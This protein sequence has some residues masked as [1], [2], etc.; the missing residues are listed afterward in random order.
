VTYGESVMSKTR[1]YEW[2]KGFQ[3]GHKNVEDDERLKRL[4]TSTTDEN[5]EKVKDIVINGRRIT[6][7]EMTDDVKVLIG[8]CHDIFLEVLGTNHEWQQNLFQNC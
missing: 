7:K 8:S 1:A 6:M 5:V 4:S 3:D 2:Y